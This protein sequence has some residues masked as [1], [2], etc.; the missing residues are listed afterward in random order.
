MKGIITACC[1][2]ILVAGCSS[3]NII[4]PRAEQP[5]P[6]QTY[7][8]AGLERVMGKDADQLER[9]FGRPIAD[10]TE[11]YG[12]KLQFGSA[13]CVLDAYLYPP[14][15]GHGQPTVRYID[16]RQRDGSPIDRASCVAALTHSK[17]RR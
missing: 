17:G 4:P 12:R 2:G 11:G 15:G 9:L 6:R 5:P 14:D 8:T 1:A 10:V 16:T 7:S 3:G 13:I